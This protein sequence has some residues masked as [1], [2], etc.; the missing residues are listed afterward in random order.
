MAK[1]D[2][3]EEIIAWQKAHDLTLRI[4]KLTSY[5]ATQW[6]FCITSPFTSGSSF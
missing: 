5:S 4:Y 1:F 2:G 6:S 3:F